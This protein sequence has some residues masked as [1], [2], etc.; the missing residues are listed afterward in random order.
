[1]KVSMP[2][3]ALLLAGGYGTR[4]RPLTDTIPKCLVQVRGKPLL[5]HWLDKLL[6]AG[7]EQVL[8][9][10]H[11]LPDLVRD[12]CMNGPWSD[13]IVLV[14]EK[15]ILGTAGTLRAND[16]FLRGH[17]TFFMAHAD[18]LTVFNMDEFMG[19]HIARP[20]TCL[21]TI[22]TFR[23]D[24]PKDCGILALDDRGLVLEVHEKVLNPPGNLANAAVF[25]LEQDVLD[26]LQQNPDASDFCRDVVPPL[27]RRWFTFFNNEFHQDI[28]NL[29]ALKRA[30]SDPY[31]TAK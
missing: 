20:S 11:Y 26:W 22:M 3:R 8:V 30:E 5:Q 16:G 19:A 2:R 9:N 10:T 7:V 4:L 6:G 29:E 12:F 18:N 31:W 15:E 1:M 24:S 25:L 28:G 14:H 21:G 13:R 27:T 23:T 17:G